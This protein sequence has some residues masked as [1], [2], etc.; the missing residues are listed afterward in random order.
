LFFKVESERKIVD[1]QN[2]LDSFISAA[3]EKKEKKKAKKAKKKAKKAEKKA[4]KNAVLQN[5]G[6]NKCNLS[7]VSIYL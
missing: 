1:L 5:M 4:K 7:E 3:K 2:K 6:S